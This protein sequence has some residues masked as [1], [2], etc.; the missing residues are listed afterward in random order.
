MPKLKEKRMRIYKLIYTYYLS[1]GTKDKSEETK[2]ALCA[3]LDDYLHFMFSN[4]QFMALEKFIH[5]G[6]L[7]RIR[8]HEESRN[9]ILELSYDEDSYTEYEKHNDSKTGYKKG[10][11]IGAYQRT[12][13]NVFDEMKGNLRRMCLLTFGKILDD[14]LTNC[15]N[16]Q[17]ILPTRS[18]FVGAEGSKLILSCVDPATIT[19]CEPAEFSIPNMAPYVMHDND[20]IF[21]ENMTFNR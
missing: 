14:Y 2:S 20:I 5:I 13:Y 9:I 19:G 7:L 15:T 4:D 11:F 1:N 16:S 3:S 10:N 17:Y 8:Y 18:A 6:R 12:Y 21:V